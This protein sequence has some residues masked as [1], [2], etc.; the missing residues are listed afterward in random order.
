MSGPSSSFVTRYPVPAPAPAQPPPPPQPAAPVNYAAPSHSTR[1]KLQMT[2][3]AASR[4]VQHLIAS[5]FQL[6]G[7]DGSERDAMDLMERLVVHL[8]ADLAGLACGYAGLSN[9]TV[10][11]ARDFLVACEERG[12]SVRELK[13]EVK[14]HKRKRKSLSLGSRPPSIVTS[15]APP[16]P[17][18]L[19]PSDSED[20]A[21]DPAV[22]KN[23]SGSGA[24]PGE[25]K[26]SA[27][28]SVSSHHPKSLLSLPAH[29]PRLPPKHTYLRTD[30]PAPAT[31]SL[32]SLQQKI[33]NAAIIQDSLRNLIQ[34]TE[35]PPAPK[36]QET[37]DDVMQADLPLPPGL[38]GFVNWE[39]ASGLRKP[40]KRWKI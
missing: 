2:P 4:A 11:H 14:A 21:K 36:H 6:A 10:P 19:L 27:S 29:F 31:T 3:H 25:G 37:D 1:N 24:A 7:F 8:L 28:K 35:A 9:R 38:G 17:P 33:N 34:A 22:E 39:G 40:L 20:E 23:G 12:M 32:S 16:K 13:A 18:E 15:A 30:P 5:R 26:P